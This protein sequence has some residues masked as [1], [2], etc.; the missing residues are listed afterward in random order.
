M[1]RARPN[2]AERGVHAASS[3]PRPE[4]SAHRATSEVRAVKRPEDRAPFTPQPLVESFYEPSAES[5]A[6]KLLGHYLLRRTPDGGWAGGAIVESEAYLANDP[7]CHGF[8][9]ETARNRSMY[10]PPGRAY[11]YFIYG[12]YFCFNAVCAHQGVA[13]AVLIRAIEPTVGEQWMSKNRP[14]TKPREVTSGP[15][16]LCLALDIK[17][18]FDGADICSLKSDLI[19]AEN[20]ELKKFLRERGPMITTT[21]I[22]L[23]IAEHLPLRFYL[24][25]S[26]YVSRRAARADRKRSV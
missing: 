14:V 16:K 5:V 6:P 11:V 4:A 13:E 24:D 22:G 15:S 10:G 8:R 17:R 7:A 23:S 18:E 1:N 21:R 19:I 2:A 12:N 9:R 20:P 25:G 26:E 3:S